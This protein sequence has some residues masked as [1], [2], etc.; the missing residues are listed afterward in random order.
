MVQAQVSFGAVPIKDNKFKMV[1]TLRT[2]A[3]L[4]KSMTTVRPL[5]LTK[6]MPLMEHHSKLVSEEWPAGSGLA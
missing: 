1:L 2:L 3:L 5:Q 6:R 4:D